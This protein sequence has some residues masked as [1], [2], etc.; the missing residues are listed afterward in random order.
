[1]AL[2]AW[3]P[4]LVL[5]I[6]EGNAWPGAAQVFLLDVDVHARLLVALPLLLGA[7][8]HVHGR[9]RGSMP[10]FIDRGIVTDA[11]RPQFEAALGSVRR[12]RESRL[13]E[14]LVLVLVYA[15]GIG[16]VWRQV[17]SLDVETWYGRA[18]PTPRG[19]RWR[20]GG[21]RS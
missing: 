7:E 9:M 6:I 16:V 5:A 12:L 15:V 19:S 17:V 13:V 3:L 14:L 20:A 18:A 21:T 2:F 11:A 1:M 8:L 10:Q 4:L